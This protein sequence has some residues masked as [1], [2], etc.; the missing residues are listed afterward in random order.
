MQRGPKRAEHCGEKIRCEHP[1][2]QDLKQEPFT[3]TPPIACSPI[4]CK[5]P[6]PGNAKT[7]LHIPTPARYPTARSRCSPRA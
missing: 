4:M 2:C 7:P 6:A 3:I 5:M 1:K